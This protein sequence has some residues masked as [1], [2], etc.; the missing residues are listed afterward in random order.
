LITPSLDE[1]AENA[2]EME[3]QG[4]RIPL[5]VGGATTS[6]AHTAIKLATRYSGPTVHVG[7]ASLVVNVLNALKNEGQRAAF[8]K[9]LEGQYEVARRRYE[10]EKAGRQPALPLDQARARAPRFDWAAAELSKPGAYGAKAWD[11]TPLERLVEHF[12]WTPFF[13]AWEL[14]AQYPQILEHPAYGAQA[15]ALYDDARRLLDDIVRNR[16]ARPRARAGFWPANSV[17]DDVEIYSDEGRTRVL[18][19]LRFLRQSREGEA[20][21]PLLCL[22]DFIAPRA[23]GKI[24][25]LGAFA[26]TSGPEIEGWARS[27]KDGGDD[28]RALIAQALA[29]RFAEALAELLHARIRKA[30]G[31]APEERLSNED[32]IKGRYR[33]IRPAYGYPSAPDHTEKAAIW[34]LLGATEA[35]MYLT[36]NFAMSP[37]ASVSG[38]YFAHP[39]SRYFSVGRL[40]RDQVEDYARRK[41]WSLA[42]AEKW[43]GPNLGY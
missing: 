8:L 7:D 39:E 1:M 29:D 35:G 41:G 14:K 40:G 28:Y 12:D 25:S 24:D 13:L 5:L 4:F 22:A 15:R 10:A 30:W 32:L 36:E 2:A 27:L 33:G 3:R 26:C 31:Y 6:R 17:G 38:L 34:E 20:G 43:L 19:T 23:S 18:T 42:E 16:R 11:D 21:A 9:D 37:A